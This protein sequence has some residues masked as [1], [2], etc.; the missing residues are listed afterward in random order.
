LS[1][2]DITQIKELLSRP[3]S[4]VSDVAKKYGVSRTTIYKYVGVIVP[5]H[6]L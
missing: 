4:S 5:E 1:Q 3:E 6:A 2:K